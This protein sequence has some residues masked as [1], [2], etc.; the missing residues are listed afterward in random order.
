[1]SR[2][3]LVGWETWISKC[4]KV[5]FKLVGTLAT[6]DFLTKCTSKLFKKKFNAEVANHSFLYF[7]CCVFF[8]KEYFTK[9]PQ[10]RKEF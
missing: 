1:M 6:F 3:I 2:I 10:V 9:F 5:K 4:Q 7:L 8:D